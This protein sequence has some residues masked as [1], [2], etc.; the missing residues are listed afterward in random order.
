MHLGITGTGMIVRMFLPSLPKLPFDRVTFFCTGRSCPVA[1][2]MV[3]EDS[4]RAYCT[5]YEKLLQTADIIYIALP[6]HLHFSYTKR[7]LEAGKDVIVEKPFTANADELRVLRRIASEN[8]CKM[9]EAV[10]LHYAPAFQLLKET[11]PDIGPVRMA[12]LQFNQFSSRYPDF[13]AGGQHAVF[14][15]KRAGGA[16]A[17]INVY[18]IHAAVMLFGRPERIHYAARIE[19]GIDTSGVLTMS[20]P[21]KHVVCCGSKDCGVPE[22]SSIHGEDGSILID[23]PVGRMT[24][25]RRIDREKTETVFT[26]SEEC[27]RMYDEFRAMLA[28]FERNDTAR[29]EELLD[30]SETVADIID[31]ARMQVFGELFHSETE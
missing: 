27:D 10:T 29:M 28:L 2:E 30:L 11:L 15:P 25:F 12:S 16:L 17:D 14:D 22:T 13:K 9:L 7:A 5:D 31:E 4:S 8:G 21:D 24:S 26:P 1:S 20:W 3:G 18:N 23:E 6:N 19:R